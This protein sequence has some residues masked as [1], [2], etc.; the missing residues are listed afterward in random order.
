MKF[1]GTMMK[2]VG[3]RSS[4]FPTGIS[5]I[6]LLASETDGT[7]RKGVVKDSLKTG[8]QHVKFKMRMFSLFP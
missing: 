3:Q 5:R 2:N 6:A 4:D 7:P 8:N 1:S